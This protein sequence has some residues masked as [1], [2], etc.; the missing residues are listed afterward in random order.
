M[1]F[2]SNTGEEMVLRYG[3]LP[4]LMDEDHVARR[5]LWS[6]ANIPVDEIPGEPPVVRIEWK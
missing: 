6:V 1:L 2:R 3:T 4:T 5:K